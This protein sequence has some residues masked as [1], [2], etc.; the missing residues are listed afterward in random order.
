M[1]F[2]YFFCFIIYYIKH[3]EFKYSG[4]ALYSNTTPM[5]YSNTINRVLSQYSIPIFSIC[6][7]LENDYETI[8]LQAC[9]SKYLNEHEHLKNYI[10][11][12]VN[13]LKI[14]NDVL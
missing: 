13:V 10:S 4:L 14:T 8:I 7:F 2:F 5:Y 9:P 6:L 12:N 1:N 11:L 3:I